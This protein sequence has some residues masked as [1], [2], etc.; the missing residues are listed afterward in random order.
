MLV[1]QSPR[2]RISPDKTAAQWPPKS[3]F[4]ALLSSPSGRKKW[5]DHHNNNRERSVSPSPVKKSS[6]ALQESMDMRGEDDEG[7]EGE[8]DLSDEETSAALELARIEAKLKLD[9]IRRKKRMANAEGGGGG[10]GGSVRSSSPRKTARSAVEVPV[11]PTK[12]LLQ[13]EHV[14]PARQRL[15]LNKPAK[16]VEVSLKRP[17]DGTTAATTKVR[18]EAPRGKTFNERL[19]ETVSLAGERE[20]KAERVEKGRS[21]GF[22]SAFVQSMERVDKG[23]ESTRS[24]EETSSSRAGSTR[25]S[26]RKTTDATTENETARPRRT[27][28]AT[29]TTRPASKPV[30]A[31]ST[32]STYTSEDIRARTDKS[33]R[34]PGTRPPPNTE[35]AVS[36]PPEPTPSSSYDSYSELHLSKRHIPHSTIARALEGKEIY[37]LPRLLK[38]VKSPDYDPPDVDTDYVVFA[39]LASKSSPYDQK[40]KNRTN[41]EKDA[42][43]DANAPR[44]KFM[45]LK[46]CDLNWEIDCFLF[47][48]A[49]DQFW[50]LVPGTVLAILNPDILPPKGSA[51]EGGRFSLK[52]GSSEDSVMEVG[53]ARD[54]KW[55]S[56]VKKDGRKCEEWVDGRSSEICEFH[57]NLLVERQRKGR[58]EVN[59]MWR[60]HG[61]GDPKD[62]VKSL[63]REEGGWNKQMNRQKGVTQSREYGTL[64]AVKSTANLLDAEDTDKLSE[65][66]EGEKSR[67]RLAA[68]EKERDLQRQLEKLTSNNESVGAEYMR[69]RTANAKPGATTS[70]AGD[71]AAREREK[72]FEKPKASEL[73]LLGN[74]AEGARMSP[75]KDRKRHFGVGA[76]NTNAGGKDAMGWGG[77]AKWGLLDKQKDRDG[78]GVVMEKGQTKL[79]VPGPATTRPSAVRARSQDGSVSPS[80]KRAR[81]MLA[82]KGLRTPGGRESGGVEVKMDDGNGYDDDDDD[83]DLDIVQ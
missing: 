33:F 21:R 64:W 12:P 28:A 57:L 14:S 65:W 27:E 16:A 13:H 38:E 40:S 62:W 24:I 44:N 52:L 18:E 47:G 71:A 46:L 29:T 15:G 53:V 72:L 61:N 4:Q 5:Q 25:S 67:V 37:P 8:D 45:V 1:R 20:A 68:K 3:P 60:G 73:G 81:F 59:T 56:S 42:Q 30:A 36:P 34:R 54:L 41:D 83:D 69:A 39:V 43:D 51:R 75:A 66:N 6:R 80:K 77:Y 26:N 7:E 17:R 11:S 22:G 82:E 74:K 70:R 35:P 58:M 63:G 9:G 79:N 78:K 49:F 48:T 23:R 50:K 10:G 76:A 32:R 19:R 2:A 31:G 55:C